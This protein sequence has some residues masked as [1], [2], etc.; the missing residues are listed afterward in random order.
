MKIAHIDSI[1]YIYIQAQLHQIWKNR[2]MSSINFWHFSC[3]CDIECWEYRFKQDV[4][5][6]VTVYLL[7]QKGQIR[8][9]QQWKE[10]SFFLLGNS[11]ITNHYKI[12]FACIIHTIL[13]GL[14]EFTAVEPF[15]GLFTPSSKRSCNLII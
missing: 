6:I 13:Q 7:K 5:S 3:S 15:A 1:N 12:T 8:A 9:T 11:K 14:F 2:D 10:S 4:I